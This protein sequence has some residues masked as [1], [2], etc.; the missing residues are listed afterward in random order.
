MVQVRLGLRSEIE[1]VAPSIVPAIYLRFLEL[2]F[3]FFVRSSEAPETD[4]GGAFDDRLGLAHEENF[5]VMAIADAVLAASNDETATR[6]VPNED[7]GLD[8][9]EKDVAVQ[10]VIHVDCIT[11]VQD[12]DVAPTAILEV[13]LVPRNGPRLLH[14]CLVD[15]IRELILCRVLLAQLPGFR[16]LLLIDLVIHNVRIQYN[17]LY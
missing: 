15:L 2:F 11:V 6:A 17:N 1:N 10:A 5:E 14:E 4:I 13:E 3:Q 8:W 16:L 12:V 7:A 9:A